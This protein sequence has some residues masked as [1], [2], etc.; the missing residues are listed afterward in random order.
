MRYW[1][2]LILSV[3]YLPYLPPWR[4]LIVVIIYYF[5]ILNKKEHNIICSCVIRVIIETPYISNHMGPL[6]IETL[7]IT[8]YIETSY[9]IISM[10]S[11]RQHGYPWPPLA[12][13]PYR[14]SPLADLKGHIPYPHIAAVCMFELAVLPLLGHMWGSIE[15]H[16]LWDRPCFSS[17][18]LYVWFV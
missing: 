17:S 12:T 3:Y 14:S 1:A 10:M 4:W 9:I 5:Q 6:Y 7:Y 16:H 11:C 8:M 15:V 13:S 2:H 18:V